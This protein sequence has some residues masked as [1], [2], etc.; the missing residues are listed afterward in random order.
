MSAP[1]LAASWMWGSVQRFTLN[2]TGELRA[3][4][5]LAQ[6]TLPV[7]AVCSIY[8]Q[9]Q[10]EESTAPA[11][12]I[13]VFTLNLNQGLGR[14]TVPRQIS[15][16][17]QPAPLSPIELTLPFVPL[18]S[19]QADIQAIGTGFG[20]GEFMR[21]ACYLQLAP[22]SRIPQDAAPDMGFGMALPGEADGQDDDMYEEL[23]DHNPELV[24]AM[25]EAQ[26]EAAPFPS[27]EVTEE[28]ASR[29]ARHRLRPAPIEA[30]EHGRAL[31]RRMRN[32]NGRGG[33]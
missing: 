13:A 32:W 12:E 24:D 3:G 29:Y 6:V 17:Q 8:F 9:A 22:V 5:Q 26:E 11:G 30:D 27:L 10:I 23:D 16:R 1:T 15:F 14:I 20:V 33:R 2:V 19:L 7:A 4:A 18:A 21:L 31:R 25:R 28:H